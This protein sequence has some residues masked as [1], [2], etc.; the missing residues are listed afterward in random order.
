[1]ARIVVYDA[2][3][4]YPAP[5]RDLLMRLATTGLCQARWTDRIHDEWT[6]NLAANRP[7]LAPSSLD[8]C[9]RLMDAHVPDSLVT[10]YEALVPTLTLPDPDDRHVLAAAI[11]AGA[12]TIVT[13]NLIDFPAAILGMFDVEAVHPDAFVA[14]LWEDDP[15]VVIEAARRQRAGLKNPPVSANEYLGTLERCRLPRAAAR[16]REAGDRI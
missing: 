12:E 4:L 15:D 16:F 9:R 1:M 5:L 6:R 3:V 14:A 10:G 8:R 2:C 11:H 13:F 7:D